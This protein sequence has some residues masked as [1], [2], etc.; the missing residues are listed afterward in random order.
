MAMSYVRGEIQWTSNVVILFS[1]HSC[2]WPTE[3]Y[4]LS[5]SFPANIEI[6]DRKIY[7]FYYEIFHSE[8]VLLLGGAHTTAVTQSFERILF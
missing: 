1:G 8:Q 5:S 4:I 3:F 2:K 7:M 6:V